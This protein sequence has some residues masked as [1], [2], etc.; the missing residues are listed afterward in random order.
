MDH[1]SDNTCDGNKRTQ[2]HIYLFLSRARNFLV[3]SNLFPRA[4]L[5]GRF[6][7]VGLSAEK[8]GNDVKN[9]QYFLTPYWQAKKQTNKQNTLWILSFVK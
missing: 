7:P 8:P 3:S 4:F 1:I 2:Y 6:S 9:S 5:P